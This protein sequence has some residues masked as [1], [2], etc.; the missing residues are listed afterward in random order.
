MWI[1]EDANDTLAACIDHGESN[2][3]FE[4][5]RSAFCYLAKVRSLTNNAD[6]TRSDAREL[7]S[8]L[9]DVYDD[10]NLDVKAVQDILFGVQSA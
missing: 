5:F 2:A 9:E 10:I 4:S 8:D 7:I 1:T 6:V 3:D